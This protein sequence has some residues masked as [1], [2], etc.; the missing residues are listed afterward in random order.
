MA[1]SDDLRNGLEYQGNNFRNFK[2]YDLEVKDGRD[3]YTHAM[4]L[5]AFYTGI[6]LY[7]QVKL[8]S[9]LDFLILVKLKNILLKQT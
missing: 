3:I 5:H 6:Y 7:I 1:S 9:S 2:S 8:I 4:Q